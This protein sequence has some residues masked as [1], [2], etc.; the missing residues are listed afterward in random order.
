MTTQRRASSR[1]PP[2]QLQLCGGP[3]TGMPSGRRFSPP[4]ATPVGATS[5]S[6]RRRRSGAQ[7]ERLGRSISAEALERCPQ[8]VVWRYGGRSS[9]VRHTRTSAPTANNSSS[10]CRGGAPRRG[11][12][13]A[14]RGPPA[15]LWNRALQEPQRR[16][17]L[18]APR[19]SPPRGWRQRLSPPERSRARP[20]RRGRSRSAAQ[21]RVMAKRMRRRTARR[22]AGNGPKALSTRRTPRSSCLP[23]RLASPRARAAALAPNS[24]CRGHRW[25]ARRH[26]SQRSAGAVWRPRCRTLAGVLQAAA[27][28]LRMEIRRSPG[29]RALPTP[30]R[31]PGTLTSRRAGGG[32]P[33]AGS[34]SRRRLGR[35]ARRRRRPQR[36]KSCLSIFPTTSRRPRQEDSPQGLTT[37]R[38][39][40]QAPLECSHMVCF[41]VMTQR[42]MLRAALLLPRCPSRSH[43]GIAPAASLSASG[44]ISR[45][46][47]G[48]PSASRRGARP[49]T[50][51]KLRIRVRGWLPHYHD[52][53][54]RVC[55]VSSPRRGSA[56][57][58]TVTARPRRAERRARDSSPDG[59]DAEGGGEWLAAQSFGSPSSVGCRAFAST[60]GH[61]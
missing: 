50:R 1:R 51:A 36:R 22:S 56:A 6:S 20:S 44:S 57:L 43:R 34:S 32:S 37:A 41:V 29:H 23:S 49:A 5:S 42:A 11:A 7:R 47:T 25:A 60:L 48:R 14:A 19:S 54:T 46:P 12:S 59:A 8:T 55:P 35:G 2:L 24:S 16:R 53:S 10:R 52:S 45:T 26:R 33:A 15:R 9:W 39:V 40:W 27:H 38:C 13:R 30:P 18:R 58:L 21:R 31:L 28:T 17:P 4:L 61:A 3:K